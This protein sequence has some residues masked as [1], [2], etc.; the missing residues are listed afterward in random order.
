MVCYQNKHRTCGIS[1]AAE[2]VEQ[3]AEDGKEKVISRIIMASRRVS[4]GLWD[5]SQGLKDNK[6]NLTMSWRKGEA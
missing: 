4:G 5:L 3:R 1:F 2:P 6:E